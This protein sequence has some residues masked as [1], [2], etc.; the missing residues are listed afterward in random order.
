MCGSGGRISYYAWTGTDLYQ[1]SRPTG[2]DAGEYQFL[3]GGVV[4]PLVTQQTIKGKVTF[5]EKF[6]TGAPNTTGA[7][8]LDLA[9]LNN[10]TAA[11]R[12]M[13]VKTDIFCS[14]SLTLPDKAGRQI[15]IGGWANDATFGIR[16]YSPS[17]S[18]GIAGTTDWQEN[19]K[20]VALQN[21]RWY[22]T[23]MIMVSNLSRYIVIVT[24]VSCRQMGVSSSLV[25]RRDQMVLQYQHLNYFLL[26]AVCCIVTGLTGPILII[27]TP[28]SLSSHL[29][30]FSLRI[31]MRLVFSTKSHLK[32]QKC[33]QT[34]Q[35]L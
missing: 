27:Y 26:P 4:I 5:L 8:E 14:A 16:F 35:Q 28:T 12:P 6:G 24:N 20:E 18:P 32:P 15:N 7:Y 13:H 33:C 22:P 23:A 1:W 30:A 17:G 31:T 25:A 10:F 34:S 21:G 3:I 9:Q 2:N 19:V 29:E 11:W